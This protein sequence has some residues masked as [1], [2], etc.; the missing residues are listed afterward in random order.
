MF[1]SII[2]EL[3]C[4]INGALAFCLLHCSIVDK[5]NLWT[6]CKCICWV[7]NLFIRTPLLLIL[8]TTQR[9]EHPLACHAAAKVIIGDQHRSAWNNVFS[10]LTFLLLSIWIYFL[11]YPNKLNISIQLFEFC[12]KYFFSCK[13][14]FLSKKH[15]SSFSINQKGFTLLIQ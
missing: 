5:I 13:P 8:M 4:K 12:G 9:I 3:Q 15:S 11:E 2:F 14:K 6:S 1:C 10:L 7:Y